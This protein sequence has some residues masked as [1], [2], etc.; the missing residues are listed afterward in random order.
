MLVR[1]I[2]PRPLACKTRILTI[3][4]HEQNKI[5]TVETLHP[6]QILLQ[7]NFATQEHDGLCNH[8]PII[9]SSFH[10]N[11]R[12]LVCSEN[13]IYHMADGRFELH[14]RSMSPMC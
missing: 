11:Y 12:I 3:K 8:G 14:F 13:F 10:Y 4:P 6:S 9:N 7:K 2:A 1:G 5:W